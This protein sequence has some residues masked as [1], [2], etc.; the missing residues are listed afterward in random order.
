[1]LGAVLASGCTRDEQAEAV[2]L[3]EPGLGVRA[4]GTRH[5]QIVRG[6]GSLVDN[7]PWLTHR[8]GSASVALP[9]LLTALLAVQSLREHTAHGKPTIPAPAPIPHFDDATLWA[10]LFDEELP[11]GPEHGA[12]TSAP[13][14][15]DAELDT[16]CSSET[17]LMRELAVQDASFSESEQKP[18]V[19]GKR[20]A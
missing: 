10:E 12:R 7:R 4:G 3:R 20:G 5:T 1:V 8:L 9:A 2:A 11:Q 6:S 18:A 14:S 16:H 17:R 15:Q 13:R 19:S